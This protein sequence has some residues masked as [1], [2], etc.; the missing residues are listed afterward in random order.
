VKPKAAFLMTHPTQY[1]APWFRALAA[2]PEITIHVYYGFRPSAEIQGKDFGVGFEWDVPLLEGYPSSFLK[3]VAAKPGWGYRNIDTPE[4]RELI[5]R[6][7]Y[8]TW[9]IN[10]WTTKS[11][12][13]AIRTC[14]RSGI[15]MMVRGDSTLI[16]RRNF[17]MR[18]VKRVVLGRWIPRFS[19]YL[20]VGKLNEKYYEHY[21]AQ[22]DRFVPV[23]HF[24]DN[25]WF[26]AR[27]K[28]ERDRRKELRS[29]WGIDADA[30]VFLFVGKFMDKKRPAD[31][32]RAMAR[33]PRGRKAHLLMV[34]DG[35]LKEAC[36]SAALEADVPVSFA[37]FL[38]QSRMPEAYAAGD[39]LVLPSAFQ[40]TWGLVVNEAMASGLPA[41]VSDKVGCAPDLVIAGVTGDT[42]PS[43]NLA[44]LAERMDQYVRMPGEES[45]QGLQAAAHI[46]DYS[47]DAATENTVRAI[48]DV[49]SR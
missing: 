24:V 40:E 48:V 39:V 2:R 3:N 43:G 13:L 12:W 21:G 25:D 41:I 42:F 10:G 20:T 1:H 4:L 31:S 22:R 16:D 19:R 46:R 32:I 8:N 37:G 15:P 6:R 5:P 27:A 29:Q 33:L 36:R 26:E 38:N 47:L 18:A 23:R 49:S 11:E 9:V 30:L 14:W 45:R 44:A 7:D 35:E 28:V 17:A 34:G